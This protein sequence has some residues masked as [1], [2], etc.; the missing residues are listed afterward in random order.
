MKRNDASQK[1]GRRGWFALLEPA[2]ARAV[3]DAGRITVLDRGAVLFRPGDDPG[4]IYGVVDGG[5]VISATGHDGLPAAGHILRRGAWFG[6]GSV[7]VRRKRTLLAEANEASTILHIPLSRLDGL[8]AEHPSL[9]PALAGLAAHGEVALVQVIADLLIAATDRRLAA[10]L[11]RVAAE[12]P[13]DPW[14]D[15]RGVPLTQQRLAELSAASIQ[16]VARF[17]DRASR[18]GWISWSYGRVRI[19][20]A[21]RLTDLAAGRKQSQADCRAGHAIPKP[22]V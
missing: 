6:Y 5:I 11:L 2:L 13:D 15:P 1:L 21:A 22:P 18:Q 7:T 19:L 12:S 17:V 4:G 10:V 9:G 14:R 3:F 8:R 16:T 20:E